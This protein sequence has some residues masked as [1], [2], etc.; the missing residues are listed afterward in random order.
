MTML[1]MIVV[2]SAAFSPSRGFLQEASPKLCDNV[3]Q[4][5]GYYKLTTGDKQCAQHAPETR[6]AKCRMLS[7]TNPPLHF[8]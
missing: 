6:R 1:Y 4:Y 5:S 2:A 3:Q 8:S 7:D